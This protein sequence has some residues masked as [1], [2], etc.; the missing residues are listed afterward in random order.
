MQTRSFLLV[1]LSHLSDNLCRRGG[2]A[3][4]YAYGFSRAR[5]QMPFDQNWTGPVDTSSLVLFVC[6][7]QP[8][9]WTQQVTSLLYAYDYQPFMWDTT[10]NSFLYAYDYQPFMWD[11]RSN[12]FFVCIWLSTLYVGHNNSFLY[13]CDYQ[14]FMWDTASNSFFVCMWLSALYV[15]H[16]I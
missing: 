11:T 15:G 3:G 8:Y 6:D 13:V 12:L 1:C 10:S 7:C 16:N 5:R 14:P 2:G 4:R 9:C